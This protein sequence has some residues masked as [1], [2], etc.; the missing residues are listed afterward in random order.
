MSD[1][2]RSGDVERR[3]ENLLRIGTVHSVDYGAA[4]IRVE[5][6]D[7]VTDWIPW[8]TTRAGPDVTWWAP[9]I[10]E[11][12]MVLA[13]GGVLED[14][15]AI[16][17]AFQ[18]AHPAPAASEN[19]HISR[20]RDGTEIRYDRSAHALSV[21]CVGDVTFSCAGKFTVTASTIHLN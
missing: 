6:G 18:D 7:L 17:A 4:R 2:F 9:E 21:N 16:G 19:V 3:L 20:Y 10:G 11:Q 1:Q 5:T 12:V 8:L 13:P 15:V 14:A